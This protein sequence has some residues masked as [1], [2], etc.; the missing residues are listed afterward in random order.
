MD[1]ESPAIWLFNG[2][3]SPSLVAY[4]VVFLLGLFA[5]GLNVV[6]GGGS[7][8]TLPLL[9]FLGLPPSVANG[10]NRV[11]IF[12]Q[13]LFAVR[14]F[15][16]HDVLDWQA[17]RWAVVPA[18]LG[19]P[20]GTWLALSVQEVTFQKVLAFLMV[21]ITLWTLWSPQ[22]GR[23]TAS[24]QRAEDQ[25]VL[26]AARFFLIGVYGGFVQAGVGF[27]ILAV[28]SVLGFDLVRG[29]AVKVFTVL[30]F[31]GMSLLH[32]VWHDKVDWPLGLAL[33]GG[34][35]LGGLLGVKLTV[36]KGHEWVQHAVTVVVIVFAL[37]LWFTA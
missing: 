16:R 14:S 15:H 7:F 28:T 1:L 8:L 3:S 2:E 27:L 33:A 17:W 23:P 6:A 11:G 36:L 26:T 24:A 20:L 35:I 5:G 19:A 31:T 21:G 25:G 10:T 13:N 12:F 4:G 22:W 32:F 30:V 34:T 37:R 18:V 29:N 9:I